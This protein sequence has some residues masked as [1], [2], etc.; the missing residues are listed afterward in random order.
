[1][2]LVEA[3]SFSAVSFLEDEGGSLPGIS[4][5]NSL[6]KSMEPELREETYV[7]CSIPGKKYSGMNLEPLLMFNEDE[8]VTIIVEKEIADDHSLSYS[9][10]WSLITL[11]V[12]S[13][14]T[15]IGF[16]A[17]LTKE[18][19]DSGISVNVVSA[20]YHDHLF[21]PVEKSKDAMQILKDMAGT[22]SQ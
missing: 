6:L 9:A 20:Y 3:I 2:P 10:I 11:T 7:F 21:V 17:K 4:D 12:H 1:M 14:L 13:D 18:L 22:E 8:G 16:L 15:A 19:A 5:L